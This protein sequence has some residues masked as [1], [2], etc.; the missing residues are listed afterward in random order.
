MGSS[1]N[2][3]I[4]EDP[5]ADARSLMY[6]SP[7]VCDGE[8]SGI[9]CKHFWGIWQKFRAANADAVRRGEKQHACTLTNGLV[10]EYTTE[11]K[12]TYCVRYE[13]RKAQG[14]VNIVKRAAIAC[15]GFTPQDG[16]GC[17]GGT[18]KHKATAGYTGFDV[19]F[20]AY[21]G[22]TI[23]E[24]NKLREDF[25][26]L[27]TKWGA[28]K[29]PAS[30]SASDIMNGEQIRIL[31]PGETMPGVLSDETESKLDGIFGGGDG[32]FTKK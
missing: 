2:V 19:E 27:P 15:V 7:C 16:S 28:G 11:E 18:K 10:L 1:E 26:D 30:M 13:P 17:V 9:Q 12:P 3:G 22:M 14:L 29:N 25:P 6:R 20:A 32:M 31:Q 5:S 8:A 23:E 21:R 24:I 4:I